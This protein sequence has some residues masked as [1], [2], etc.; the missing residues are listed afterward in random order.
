M[1]VKNPLPRILICDDDRNLHL[2]LKSTLGKD[3]D[4]RSAYKAEEALLLLKKSTT[5]I[6]LL[7]MDLGTGKDGLT[8]I[9]KV[10]EVQ[11]DIRIILF[12]GSTD[13]E[14]VRNGMK[15]GAFDYIQ[16]GCGLEE[17]R[18]GF[19]KALEHR[20]LKKRTA[21]TQRELTQNTRHL[22][23]IGKSPAIERIR[24]QIDRA[25]NSRAPVLIQGE[26]GTGKEVVARMLRKTLSDG[27][28]E[29]FV[30]VDSSTI[31][32]S[33][34]E[35]ILFGY[36]KGAFTGAEKS[37]PGLFEEADGGALYFDELGNMPLEI[38]NKLLRAIQEKEVLRIGS[39]R[40]LQ[41][42]FRVIAATNR[43]I[44]GMVNGGTF[45]DDLYQRINVLQ[46]DLPPLRERPEDIP[47]LLEHFSRIHAEGSPPLRFL[48]ETLDLI[49]R[50]PFP[51][52]IRE[53]SNLVLYLYTMGES[54]EVS[55]FD[56][57]P[58]FRMQGSS[59]TPGKT[60]IRVQTS[61]GEG[62]PL[63]EP[64]FYRAVEKFE[65]TYLS[66]HYRRLNA[67]VSKMAQELGMDRSYLHTK[68]KS[69]GIHQIK[70]R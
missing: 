48:P 15:L 66:L 11:S 16:K 14:L 37:T 50:Y 33:V 59:P 39:S 45:K 35:S 28:L 38:Q 58:K 30:A 6:L 63:A 61:N 49:E 36:E 40:P 53:L 22:T 69:Y 8:V 47:D 51:G 23:L 7:D 9:P 64:D 13:F 25:R 1:I 12:S 60:Q 43:E 46:I 34:A 62:D 2:G 21:Q 68:L 4:I 32:S 67:N 27:L 20:E 54:E 10:L 41:L 44:Q 56:L 29:P 26:T 31:Q 3:F 57:P 70:G 19:T 52:N 5:D 17:L 24:R 55:P 18:H 65:K 42:D